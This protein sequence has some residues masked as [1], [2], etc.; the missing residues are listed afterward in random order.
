LSKESGGG[1]VKP[2][3]SNKVE[4]RGFEEED[5]QRTEMIFRHD[6]SQ[7]PQ[8][9]KRDKVLSGPQSAGVHVA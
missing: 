8:K 6:E 7:W 9:D 4:V 3:A 2:D 5:P 1:F